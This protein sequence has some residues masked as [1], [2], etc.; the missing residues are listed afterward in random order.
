MVPKLKS[1]Q[2]CLKLCT[3]SNLTKVDTNLTLIFKD[4]IFKIKVRQIGA[5]IK[6]SLDLLE[7]VY[8]SQFEGAECESNWF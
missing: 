7:N 6:I 3:L 2:K 4:F 8:S 5:N 1:R